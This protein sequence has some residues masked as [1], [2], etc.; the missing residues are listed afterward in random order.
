MNGDLRAAL[1]AFDGKAISYLSETGVRF[2]E[3]PDYLPHLIE[4]ASDRE[5]HMDAGATWLVKDHLEQGGALPPGMTALLL[6]AL[7]GDPSWS[8]A[9]HILQSVRFLDLA[10]VNGANMSDCIIALTQHERPFLR[11]W[12]VDAIWRLA[13][14][15]PAL[16]PRSE[17]ALA[18]AQTDPAASVRARARQS[19]KE[20]SQ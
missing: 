9:L 18:A 13:E 10:E 19:I 14:A 6:Q 16:Q 3:A 17:R 7:V 5:A 15:F 1:L 11:A 20:A 8:A 2:R 12:A 4:L